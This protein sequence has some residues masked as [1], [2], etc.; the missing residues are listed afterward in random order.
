MNKLRKA[1]LTAVT[2]TALAIGSTHASADV[3]LS[4]SGNVAG[5]Q[6][7]NGANNV[8]GPGHVGWA[9]TSDWFTFQAT[10]AGSI[11]VKVTGSINS[12]QPAFTVWNSGSAENSW[13]YGHSYNQ[14]QNEAVGTFVGFSNSDPDLNTYFGHGPDKTALG[15]A[16]AFA[17]TVASYGIDGSGNKFAELVFSNLTAGTW[18]AVAAGGSGGST[19]AYTITA[20][21]SAVPVPGA[22]WLFGSA[23]AGLVGVSR[24]KRAA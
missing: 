24:R 1:V 10:S 19:G 17:G 12:V 9:H 23:I 20:N 6:S 7:W 11:D 14:I 8:N 22:V 4:S 3:L 16:N 5:A 18:Y 15:G 2:G 21:L 13:S